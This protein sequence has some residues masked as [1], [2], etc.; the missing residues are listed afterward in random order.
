MSRPTVVYLGP[1]EAVAAPPGRLTPVASFADSGADEHD[2]LQPALAAIAAG[3]ANTLFVPRLAYVASSLG[4]LLR[5][6]QWLDEAG[7][8]LVAADIDLDTAKHSGRRAI[9]LLQEIDRWGREGDHRRRPRGRP[10]LRSGAPEL[11]E[12]IAALHHD[13]L[14]LRAIAD[15]LN[16]EG[17]PTPRGGSSWRP[18]SVQSALGYRRPRPPGPGASPPPPPHPPHER[19]RPPKPGPKP[20]PRP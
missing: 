4:E 9:S 8:S 12:R 6:L 17:V 7:S 19:P 16:A 11:A 1:N 14:S 18:S 2:G 10:G 15:R 13:G 20:G 5:L 3:Q